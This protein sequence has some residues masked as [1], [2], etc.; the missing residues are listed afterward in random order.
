MGRSR[1]R[2]KDRDRRRRDGSRDRSRDRRRRRDE[3]REEGK[4]EGRSRKPEEEGAPA[5]ELGRSRFAG[6]AGEEGERRGGK[7][8][9]KRQQNEEGEDFDES[10]V[11]HSLRGLKNLDQA[12][13]HLKPQGYDTWR[14]GSKKGYEKWFESPEEAMK[15]LQREAA[16]REKQDAREREQRE[17]RE[18]ERAERDKKDKKEKK[19]DKK[20]KKKKRSRSGSARR[21]ERAADGA[22]WAATAAN[23][24]AGG[25]PAIVD[26]FAMPQEPAAPEPEEEGKKNPVPAV[27]PVDAGGDGKVV[28]FAE[29][30]QA[31]KKQ[32]EAQTSA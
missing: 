21:K 22:G 10:Q 5:E 4:D 1:S 20:D 31:L 16:E 32:Q 12:P 15:R 6:P 11:D 23:L 13:A 25:G 2:S 24:K 17:K 26:P 19:K 3:K 29:L 30:L 9:G 27:A 14:Q 18:A 8:R 7:G 28:K